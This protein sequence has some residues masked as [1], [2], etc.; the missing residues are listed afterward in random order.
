MLHFYWP[1]HSTFLSTFP[2]SHDRSSP[3][4][5][6]VSSTILSPSSNSSPGK[7]TACFCK[8]RQQSRALVDR[9]GCRYASLAFPP[10]ITALSSPQPLGRWLAPALERNH[11]LPYPWLTSNHRTSVFRTITNVSFLVLPTDQTTRRACFDPNRIGLP[12]P[13][14]THPSW[15]S[16]TVAS[17]HHV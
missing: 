3:G 10:L 2:A 12:G 1:L 5:T 16:E 7:Q 6:P 9:H 17:S 4:P 13:G 8:C 14:L 15:S 11:I